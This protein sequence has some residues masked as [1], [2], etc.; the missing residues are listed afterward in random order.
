MQSTVD[1]WKQDFGDAYHA[2]NRPDWAARI[3]FWES[4]I[5]FCTPGSVLEVG[6]GPGWNLKAIQKTAPNIDLY[7]VDVNA[8]AVE[9]ARQAGFEA[10]CTD[11]LGI[12]GLHEPGTIDLVFTAGMLIHVAP[13]DLES[14][15]RAIVETSGK[16]VLA[17]EYMAEQEEEIDYRGHKGKLWK[18]PF[19][20]LY[21]AMGLRLL[22]VGEA[23]G[24]TECQYALLEKP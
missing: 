15:M 1:F 2:R 13:E 18:R 20:K 14:V 8:K 7:G 24:F 22:S 19:G 16:Y 3:P 5:Q 21:E 12:C 4:A 11:A 10:Q 17:V 9:E 6:C 23:G